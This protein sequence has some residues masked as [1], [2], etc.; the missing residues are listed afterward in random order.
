MSHQEVAYSEVYTVCT[1]MRTRAHT[2]ADVIQTSCLLPWN[3]IRFSV[4]SREKFKIDIVI[5][6]AYASFLC[7]TGGTKRFNW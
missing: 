3:A 6:E 1:P 2:H 5:N 7:W 4:N